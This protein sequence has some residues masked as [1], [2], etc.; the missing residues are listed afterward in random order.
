[1]IAGGDAEINGVARPHVFD[2]NRLL[3]PEFTEGSGDRL[4]GAFW[5]YSFVLAAML[6]LSASILPERV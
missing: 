5:R 1:M 4:F 3:S 2:H 6:A